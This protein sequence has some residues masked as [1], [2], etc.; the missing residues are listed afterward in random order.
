LA[1][2]GK[3]TIART[4]ARKYY[5]QK[6]LGASFFFSR[7]GGDVGNASKFVT[8]IAVQL[9]NNVPSLQKYIS[10][11]IKDRTDIASQ[12]LRDQW[13]Q[14]V[15]G[16]LS[17]LDDN[18]CRS[19]Y[20]LVVDALDECENENDIRI[21]LSLFS[22]AR[23]LDLVRLQIFITSRPE[24]PIRQGVYQIPEAEHQ[25]FVLH[26]ICPAIVDHDITIF[27]EH[28]LGFIGQE[29]ALGA[30][31]PGGKVIQRLVQHASGLFIWAATACRFIREGK[32]FAVERLRTILEGSNSDII[33]PEKHLDE[34]YNT[35][36]KHSI[37]TEYTDEEK[38]E[39]YRMLR[40]TLGSVVILLFPLS[41]FS[42]S[43]LLHLPKENIDQTLDD[44]HAILNIPED[45]I[46]PLRLHHPSFRDF[47]LNKSRCGDTEFWVDEK[48]AHR[49]MADRCIRLMSTKL[50]Q[51]IC[52]QRGPGIYVAD[53]E[54]V[55][56]EDC[57]LPEVQ[58]ACLYWVQ[59]LQKCGDGLHDNG[60]IHEFL[61][62]HFLHWLEALSWMRKSAEGILAIISLEIIAFV[63][64][65][66]PYQAFFK[67]NYDLEQRLS[68]LV[69]VYP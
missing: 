52:D 17:K 24:V 10:E 60:Q 30:G 26:N 51:D 48:Y 5:G 44:L 56:V 36:L 19:L 61:L 42:L 63:S 21:I 8:S 50:K 9:A 68:R 43:T 67:L 46:R 37:S 28:E 55:R 7:G 16:P 22:E 29:R 27:L 1:G 57:L 62:T 12:S 33:V 23:S 11:A 38:T 39:L 59:H 54:S 69:R 49:T 58:Y 6:H 45:Q 13:R 47:L 2:T 40:I 64:L 20:V 53:V 32:R 34:I 66:L 15:L 4:V 31:W 35:V 41:A 65:S 25:D 14:L 18:S 3:S